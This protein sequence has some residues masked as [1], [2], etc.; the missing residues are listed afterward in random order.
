MVTKNLE[1][2]NL[3]KKK[4]LE[5]RTK[6][7]KYLNNFNNLTCKMIKFWLSTKNEQYIIFFCIN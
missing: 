7:T 1:F 3:S 5:F 2:G 6:T 4:K